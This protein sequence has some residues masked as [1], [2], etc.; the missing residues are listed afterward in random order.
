[1]RKDH[2]ETAFVLLDIIG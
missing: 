1:M 2:V